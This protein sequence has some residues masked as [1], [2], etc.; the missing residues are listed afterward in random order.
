MRLFSLPN[1]MRSFVRPLSLAVAACLAAVSLPAA[2][3]VANGGSPGGAWVI[4]TGETLQVAWTQSTAA[5]NVAIGS[6]LLNLS[7]FD[8]PEVVQAFLTTAVGPG[9]TAAQQIAQS[10]ISVNPSGSSPAEYRLFGGLDLGPGTYYLTLAGASG[11]IASTTNGPVITAP[12]VTFLGSYNSTYFDG[13]DAYAPASR[14]H[15]LPFSSSPASYDLLFSVT[16][17]FTPVSPAPE[18]AAL[19]LLLS[20]AV[21]LWC[22]CRGRW[23]SSRR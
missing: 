16:G 21:M 9:T 8:R 11:W 17:D 20:G 1:L 18:P 4:D 15:L 22:S 3:L 13:I 2:S 19:S 23:Q 5:T 12:G 6:T 10:S 14:F 7:Y